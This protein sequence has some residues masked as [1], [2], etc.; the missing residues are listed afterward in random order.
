MKKQ[1]NTCK[2]WIPL[3]DNGQC[4]LDSHYCEDDDSCKNHKCDYV[5]VILKRYGRYS[6]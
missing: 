6:K 5:G 4:D 3:I 1:C 2:N